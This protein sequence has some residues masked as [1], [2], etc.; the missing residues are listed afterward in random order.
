MAFKRTLSPTFS[1]TVTVNVPND[2][3]GFD[4]STFVGV[5]NRYSADELQALRD[6][7][8]NNRDLV[9]KVLVG[10]DMTDDATK[11]AVP[12]TPDE[13]E[14]CLQIEPTPLA[15]ALAFWETVNGAR[16]KN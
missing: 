12:F 16:T 2:K 15:T 13:L 3:G 11:A 6:Q 10:W 8:L 14:A 4:K 9:R 7:N 5:F 1:T